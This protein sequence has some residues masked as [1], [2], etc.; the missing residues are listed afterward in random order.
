M[1]TI[2][3]TLLSALLVST[4]TLASAAELTLNIDQL[5]SAKGVVSLVVFSNAGTFNSFDADQAEGFISQRAQ[6]G[7][8]TFSFHGLTTG[9]YAVSIHHDE[10]RNGELDMVK[11]IPKEGYAYSNN[12]GK[13]ADPTF[14]KASFF[15]SGKGASQD[16]NMIYHD[17]QR[18][19]TIR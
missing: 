3:K 11:A 6:T 14:A 4:A 9:E 18:K 10:N 13:D 16:I 19:E 8:M 2:T 7:Q 5:R 15:V 17:T 12:V 1:N